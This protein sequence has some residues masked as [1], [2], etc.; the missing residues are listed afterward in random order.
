MGRLNHVAKAPELGADP[1]ADALNVVQRVH[2]AIVGGAHVEIYNPEASDYR[3][4]LD[5][6]APP[7]S[8]E[9]RYDI[10]PAGLP[11]RA[12]TAGTTPDQRISAVPGEAYFGALSVYVRD[13]LAVRIVESV[14]IKRRLVA[15]PEQDILARLADASVTVPDSVQHAGPDGQSAYIEAAI[16]AISTRRGAPLLRQ[17]EMALDLTGL[18][19]PQEVTMPTETDHGDLAGIL[20]RGQ[21]LDQGQQ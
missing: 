17:R 19:A 3:R 5:P 21:L 12:S 13:G 4:D 9:V 2:D 20:V 1:V 14:D 8:N 10:R 18:G 15:D 7:P 16:N 6:F 11:P